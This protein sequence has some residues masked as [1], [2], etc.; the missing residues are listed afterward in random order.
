MKTGK[1]TSCVNNQSASK[2]MVSQRQNRTKRSAI[3]QSYKISCE[4]SQLVDD[5]ANCVLKKVK[6]T[7]VV[8]DYA[9]IT[10]LLP[11]K[12]CIRVH[13][14]CKLKTVYRADV[15]NGSP[16]ILTLPLGN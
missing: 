11:L 3:S 13:F 12:C 8:G 14:S 9:S 6:T 5:S 1:A 2:N 10:G 15:I 7:F 4:I 16:E